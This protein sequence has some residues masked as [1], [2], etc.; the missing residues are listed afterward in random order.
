MS[1][2]QAKSARLITC[3]AF[4]VAILSSDQLGASDAWLSSADI[5]STFGGQTIDG[6]YTDKRSFSER[7]DNDGSLEYQEPFRRTAGRWSVQRDTFCTI[8]DRDPTGGCFRVKRVSSNCFE[9]YFVARSIEQAS[10]D[11]LRPDAWTA[12]GWRRE[13]PSTCEDDAIA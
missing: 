2:Q 8:Y 7:Y 11:P 12:R 9:F 6:R 4:V 3:A 10:A 13:M 5:Q 1:H